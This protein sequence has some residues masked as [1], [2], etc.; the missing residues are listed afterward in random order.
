MLPNRSSDFFENVHYLLF[1]RHVEVPVGSLAAF[2]FNCFHDLF[3]V[4]VTQI[5]NCDFC[6]FP[7]EKSCRGP[8]NAESGTGDNCYFVP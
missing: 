4:F 5:G 1:A 6:A 2:A 8:T 7:R 3:S